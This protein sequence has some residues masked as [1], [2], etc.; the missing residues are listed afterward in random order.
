MTNGEA[1][2]F[3]SADCD[4]VSLDEFTD[5]FKADRSLVKLNLVMVGKSIHEV[6]GRYGLR[7]SVFPLPTLNQIVEEKRDDIVRLDEGAV[8]IDDAKAISVPV[9]RDSD[10]GF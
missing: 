1:C 4:L 5:V 7:D 9:R 2:A 8:L 6:G 3:F 10:V